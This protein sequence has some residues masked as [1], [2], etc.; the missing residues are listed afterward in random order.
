MSHKSDST[1]KEEVDDSFFV[2]RA[3]QQQ[4]ERLNLVLEEVKDRMD[5]QEVVIRNL[6]GGQDRRRRTPSV[7]NEFENVGDDDD[8]EDIASEVGMG[9]VDRPRGGRHGRGHGRNL[10]GRDG[11][12]R[13]LGSMKIKIP[14]FQGRTDPEA[15]LEW[16]K[17]I[18]LIFDCHNYSEKKK[19]KLAVIE[20]TDYAIIWWDQLVTNRRRNHERPIETWGELKALIR[21]RFVPSHYYRDLYQKLQNLIQGSRSVEDYYKEINIIIMRQE[22]WLLSE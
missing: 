17:K 20:F 4:F 12:D 5:Q 21:R 15:Y 13:N 2:L 10:M 1:P 6:Q 14:S 18:E 22:I 11:V 3:M 19:V 16:V 7:E 8:E 9:G